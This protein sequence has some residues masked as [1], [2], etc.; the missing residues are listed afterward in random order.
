MIFRKLP[1][2][3][4]YLIDLDKMEDNR[5]FFA[6]Y[7]CKNEFAEH[8][9]VTKWLQFNTSF[10]KKRAT[11]RGL[12][13]Q[14]PP[15]A[16]AKLIRV[17]RGSIFDVIVDIRATSPT[18]GKW[19]SRELNE[20]N[21]SMMYVPIGFAHGFQTLEDDCEL[22]YMHSE[23][24]NPDAEGAINILDP[25]ISMEWPLNIAQISE[26]DGSHPMININI[27]KSLY[28]YILSNV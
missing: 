19:I 12:H 4:S 6:R 25:E 13:F 1:L 18:Y 9:L 15:R 10:T 5:G 28:L 23:F 2:K 16:E 11:I 17:I 24:Y 20:E 8:G 3:G 14:R 26:R 27:F 7:Y 21:R 22:L